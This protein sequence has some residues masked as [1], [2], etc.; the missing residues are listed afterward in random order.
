M[1]IRRPGGFRKL[2]CWLFVSLSGTAWIATAGLAANGIPAG[3]A[4]TGVGPQTTVEGKKKIFGLGDVIV[5]SVTGLKGG[6]ETAFAY[7]N[8]ILYLGGFPL[9]DHKPISVGNTNCRQEEGAA[10]DAETDDA[11]ELRYHLIRGGDDEKTKRA[12]IALL[13]APKGSTKEIPIGIGLA[14]GETTPAAPGA[15]LVIMF[16]IFSWQRLFLAGGIYFFMLVVFLGFAR[17]SRIIR[18]VAAPDLPQGSQPPYSLGRTQM[19]WWLFLVLGAY[20]FIAVITGDYETISAQSLILI[21]IATGTGMGAMA[22]DFDKTGK[23]QESLVAAVTELAGLGGKLKALKNE[24]TRLSKVT[25]PSAEQAARLVV[26]AV[27]VNE[28]PAKIATLEAKEATARRV[29]KDPTTD[30]FLKDL[31]KD[32]RGVSFHRFQ[33]V[34]W[35][36]VLAFVFVTEVYQSLAM[37]EFSATLLSL[38]GITAGTYLGFKF[39]E[40]KA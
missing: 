10:R 23:A 31:V 26:L 16:E 13:G 27:E 34:V 40:R 17:R 14:S 20:L 15:K 3:A 12:W 11:V 38:M 19:A 9:P 7:Q 37:P 21:G 30:G 32:R 4:V 1:S 33:I 24:Q 25:T 6:C 2:V 36:V 18:D 8:L 35:S 39:P 29:L 22:I 28:I 5:V